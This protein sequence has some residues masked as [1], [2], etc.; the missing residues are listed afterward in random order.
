MGNVRNNPIKGIDDETVQNVLDE[1]N[2]NITRAAE[3]L[4]V[5]HMSLRKYLKRTPHVVARRT[6]PAS[7]LM[8][9]PRRAVIEAIE[10]ANGNLSLASKILG[11]D[12][13]TLLE[14]RKRFVVPVVRP[15]PGGYDALYI[16]AQILQHKGNIEGT[17]RDIDVSPQALRDW[18]NRAPQEDLKR[19]ILRIRPRGV[20]GLTM[21]ETIQALYDHNW[22][23][24][25][26]ARTIGV[27]DAAI[28]NWLNRNNL[29][30][31][32]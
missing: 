15:G 22:N 18:V 14:Y 11:V 16:R 30:V 19:E 31:K 1:H 26:T 10:E 3:E 20:G 28:H 24:R 21:E 29:E 23:I 2:G 13:H 7:E 9:I 12:R 27:T 32:R 5:H 4:G 8:G 6:A 17:A 25:A